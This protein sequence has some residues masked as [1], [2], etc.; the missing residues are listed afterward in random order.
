MKSGLVKRI[1]A[2]GMMVVMLSG[3]VLPVTAETVSGGDYNETVDVTETGSTATETGSNTSETGNT[4]T[5]AG[6]TT[7]ETGNTTTA[8]GDVT[9]SGNGSTVS[10][11]NLV[12]IEDEDVPLAAASIVTLEPVTVDGVTIIVSGPASAFAEGTTVSAVA[13]EPAEVVIEAAEENEKATV[14]KYKAFDINLVCNGK[15]VQPLNGEQITVNF[16]GDML[17]P[18]VANNE[19]V[20]VYHVDENDNLTKMD[21]G[22][23]DA[24]D[25][26]EAVTEDTVEMTTTHFSTYLILVT[27]VVSNRTVTFEHLLVNNIN[28]KNAKQFYA[29]STITLTEGQ[30]MS[31]SNLPIQG[32]SNYTLLKVEVYDEKGKMVG[33]PYINDPTN[34][35]DVVIDLKNTQ[36][37]VKLFYKEGN[38]T[39]TNEVTF[40][41]YYVDTVDGNKHYNFNAGINTQGKAIVDGGDA[42]LAMGCSDTA[43]NYW[44]SWNHSNGTM[45]WRNNQGQDVHSFINFYS[46]KNGALTIN[47]NNTDGGGENGGPNAI[48]QGIVDKLDDSD[49][50]GYYETVKYG[51]TSDGKQIVDGG[52]FT[53]TQDGDYKYV[54]NNYGLAFKQTGNTYE[55][56]YVYNVNDDKDITKSK[57]EEGNYS[58]RFLPLNKVAK[59]GGRDKFQ[60]YSF[61]IGN[62]DLNYYFGMRYDFTFK[63]GD[64]IGDLYYEFVGDDDLWVFVDGKLVLDLGGLHSVYPGKYLET[65]TA[66]KVDIWDAVYGIKPSDRTKANWWTELTDDEKNKEHTVTVLYMERGGWDSSCGMKFVIPNVSE[67]VP[68]ITTVPR[69]DV[70]L[71]K[72][73]EGTD[74]VISGVQFTMYKNAACTEVMKAATT[75]TNGL[76]T[77]DKLR[78]GT[79]YIKETGYN[80]DEYFPNDTIY[81]V[82][83]TTKGTGDNVV[84]EAVV[85]E[86]TGNNA[87]VLANNIVYNKPL[88]KLGALKIVKTVDKV[89]TVHGNA[90]FTFKITCPDGSILYRAMTF[91]EEGT[92]AVEIKDLPVGNYKVEELDTIRYELAEGYSQSLVKA[93]EANKTTNYEFSNTKVF[94]KYYSHADVAVNVVTF[95]RD[96]TGK[97]ISSDISTK[98]SSTGVYEV[99]TGNTG[100]N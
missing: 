14:K 61:N 39:F 82:V 25:S 28:D 6:S 73:E 35:S 1:L 67:V 77:F 24:K 41:D 52:Y 23:V 89:N 60:P 100:T 11:G 30:E 70:T 31:Y 33:S 12:D 2:M 29:P 44:D 55:L 72:L 48:V 58:K 26:V 68:S 79:Y 22:V 49:K 5:G 8:E 84:A 64:Y 36:N 91:S 76:A 46:S 51:K 57:D 81:K 69:T 83:V 50:D 34:T 93:V 10:D 42:F 17:I 19:D 18:D 97:I 54:Y 75:D 37:T 95:N 3:D 38:Q 40:Y 80:K 71:K 27:D 47:D 9:V 43:Y 65:P 21:A 45:G 66:N 90:T 53:N 85:Y 20:A 87:P 86:G 94:E 15:F 88:P 32:G 78:E 98:T 63:V 62:Q 13:V 99:E 56:D 16:E 7:T 96:E 4:A 74:D 92:K 59:Q